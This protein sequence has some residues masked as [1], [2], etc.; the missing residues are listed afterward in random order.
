MIEKTGFRGS[1]ECSL[2]GEKQFGEGGDS[3]IEESTGMT[4]DGIVEK[5]RVQKGQ[6][7]KEEL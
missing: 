4:K 5:D 6:I 2:P 1:R 3:V 7:F